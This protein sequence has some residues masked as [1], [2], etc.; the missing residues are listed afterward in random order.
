MKSARGLKSGI[1]KTPECENSRVAT[2]AITVYY[3]GS[4]FS[5]VI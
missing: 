4:F 3:Q 1:V 2:F 5:G